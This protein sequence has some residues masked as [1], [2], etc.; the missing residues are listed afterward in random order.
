[1]SLPPG[2][3]LHGY[4]IRRQLGAGGMGVVYLA[5]DVKLGRQVAIKV[6]SGDFS[7]NSPRA[8]RFEQ[9]A[10]PPQRSTIPAVAPLCRARRLKMNSA[11]DSRVSGGGAG[12]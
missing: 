3:R 10:R 4:D 8:R 11:L 2:S 5:H 7:G 6:L 9:E 1:M 12:T